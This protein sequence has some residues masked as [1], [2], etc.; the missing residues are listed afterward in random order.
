MTTAGRKPHVPRNATDVKADI[1][2]VYFQNVRLLLAGAPIFE[3]LPICTPSS[4]PILTPSG[5]APATAPQVGIASRHPK[6]TGGRH[7]FAYCLRNRFSIAS[8]A[9]I[10]AHAKTSMTTAVPAITATLCATGASG[11]ARIHRIITVRNG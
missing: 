8:L 9:F 3:S 5:V 4:P 1:S 7:G 11:F 2:R 10:A 6:R